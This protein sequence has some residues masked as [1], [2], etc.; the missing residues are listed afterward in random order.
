MG[1]ALVAWVEAVSLGEWG[2]ALPLGSTVEEALMAGVA[3]KSW[4]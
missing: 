3:V 2:P 4:P 1:L